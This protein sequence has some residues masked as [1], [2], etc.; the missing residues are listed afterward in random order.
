MNLPFVCIAKAVRTVGFGAVSVVL[1]LFLMERGFSAAAVGVLFSLTLIEDALF[2]TFAS[3]FASRIGMR[4][5]LL[6][7]S[8]VILLGGFALAFAEAQWMIALA[9]IFGI[10][11]P[12]G[13][14]GGPFAPIEQ[15][16]IAKSVQK[17]K[18]TSSFTWYNLSGFGGAALGA[19][20]AGGC[21]ALR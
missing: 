2:T 19:L 7:A 10:V 21:V 16:I 3:V 13:F 4:T 12:A 9:V 14:E 8:V 1:A 20:L 11:S 15:A 5:I 18:L 17:E 6:F